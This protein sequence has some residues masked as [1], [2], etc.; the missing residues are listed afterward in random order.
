MKKY[1]L[2]ILAGLL[3]IVSCEKEAQTEVVEPQDEPGAQTNLIPLTVKASLEDLGTKSD[4]A[5]DFILWESSDKIAVFDGTDTF[6]EFTVSELSP[7]GKG[8][9]F[10]GSAAAASSYA[11]VAPFSA[12]S[13]IKT[14]S[15]RLSITVHGSQTIV[16]SHSVDSESL[17]STAVATGT[18]DLAFE[19][20][21]ALLK[22]K[23]ESSNV[24]AVTVKGNNNESISGTSHFYY[25]GDGAPR[26]DL[27]NAGGKQVTLT[28][29]ATADAAPSAFPAGEYYIA[30]WPTEFSGGYS[31]IL[32]DA[33][34][35][36][37]I[38]TNSNPQSIA[39]NGGQDL[40]T[41]DDFTFCPPV[42]T[43]AAQL[44]MWRRVASHGAYAEGDEVKLG[45]DINLG[46]YVWTPVPEFLGI[47]D[48]QG[49]KIYNFT[50]S[51]TDQ[52]VGFIGTLGS[53]NAEEAVLKDVVFGSSDGSTYD[54]SSSITITGA[55][56][57]WT[58][59]G[60]VGYAQ[61]KTLVSGVT[62]FMP[63]T[64]AASVT[65]KHGIGGIVG[66][67]DGGSGNGI[68]ITGC[69]NYGAVT[70]NSA[71]E[72]TDNSA[73][74]GILGSTDGSHP[75]VSNCVNHAAIQNNC[76]GV[77]RLGG[78]VGK[79]WDSNCAIDNCSNEGNIINNA[80]SVTDKTSSWDNAV[81]VGGV[82]GAFTNKSGGLLVNKCSNSGAICFK[83]ATNGSYRQA[84]GGVVG[85]VTYA[86]T[87]KGCYNSG[88]IYDDASCESHIAM[89]GILGVCNTKNL[90]VTKADDNTYNVNDGEIFHYKA[91]TDCDTY[92]GGIVGLENSV[93]TPVE[94]SINNGRLVS[95]PSGQGTANYYTG[96]ICG[97]SSGVIR[98]CTNNGYIFTW[99]GSLTAWIGGISGG[100]GSPQEISDCTNNGWLSPYNTTGSSVCGGI[101]PILKPNT[102][103]VS[104]C[105]NTGMITTGNFY[106]GGSGNNP[107]TA[108]RTFQSKDYYMGGLFGY[109]EEPTVDVTVAEGCIVACTF[110]QR[111][112]SESKD[113]FKG[114]ICGK[115]MSTSSTGYK[116]TFGS[117]AS[118]VL[119][120][121]TTNFQYG[122]N[123]TPA[124]ITQGD[125]ITTTALANKWLMGSSSSLYN[126]TNGSSNTAKVDFN[127]SLVTSAQAGIE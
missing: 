33:D 67:G 124:V 26:V 4:I 68:T 78:I 59:G 49:H 63:V 101:L 93:T 36:K 115:T 1:L 5:E 14:D 17:V 30:I 23:L 77:S 35:A 46:G 121:N 76:I 45:A 103:S 71:S 112:G 40:S 64:A 127:Y 82:L 123:A 111:T 29:K 11:A 92:V 116:V 25:G 73:I 31:V 94:Y 3:A 18:T 102:T 20:Q 108:L 120:V 79:A 60:V 109:V 74:G 53:S 32:T 114:I 28:Y 52:Y 105:T 80:A 21:F 97:S 50:I 106:S 113:S 42:I 27:T 72:T 19:N 12:A 38:K 88:K 86:G 39:R 87:I 104:N 83:A 107:N 24:T 98:H 56:S 13:N 84:F 70:D 100:K 110:G 2:I 6:K 34:G 69:H 122:T 57:G 37:S 89:G 66:V 117:A 47:F 15:Q 58:Y 96:G 54:G 48:G 51:S 44:K 81:G 10:S 90:V 16:G 61:K 43:T 118:P 99:A 8:A 91:H 85:L 9:E 62:S 7:S 119:I 95:D 75:T 65:G 125:V 22:I 126:A 55:R 41:I